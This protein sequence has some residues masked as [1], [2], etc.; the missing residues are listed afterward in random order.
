MHILTQDSNLRAQ[1][2]DME[3]QQVLDSGHAFHS[4]GVIP[5]TNKIMGLMDFH[6]T[7]F[8]VRGSTKILNTVLDGGIDIVGNNELNEAFKA[9]LYYDKVKFDYVHYLGLGLPLLNADGEIINLRHILDAESDEPFFVKPSSDRKDFNFCIVNPGETLF[10]LI[11]FNTNRHYKDIDCLVNFTLKD[12]VKEARFFV[13]G[14]EVITG[15]YYQ[16]NKNFKKQYIPSTEKIFD[17]AKEYTKLFQP[18]DNFVI[19]IAELSDGSFEIIEYNCLNCSGLYN[20]N[21]KDLFDALKGYHNY[22]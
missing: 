15:S 10:D 9:K 14:N 19:D 7:D 3:Y 20:I 6:E 16:I 17:V 21:S 22:D 1:Y 18:H 8:V 11:N 5:F 13:V 2:I 4:Y 12:I